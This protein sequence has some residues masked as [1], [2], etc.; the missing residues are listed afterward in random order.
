MRLRGGMLAIGGRYDEIGEREW[1]LKCTMVA[2]IWQK[3]GVWA[4]VDVQHDMQN[5]MFSDPFAIFPP[6]TPLKAQGPRFCYKKNL[7]SS[8][9]HPTMSYSL[10]A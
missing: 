1:H 2:L 3:R 9:P 4:L 6:Y 10:A 5:T 7:K 8:A